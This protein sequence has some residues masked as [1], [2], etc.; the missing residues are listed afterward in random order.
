MTDATKMQPACSAKVWDGWRRTPCARAGKVE[1]DG[2]WFCR[3]HDP[4]AIAA[5]RAK[6]DAIYRARMAAADA[7]RAEAKRKDDLANACVEAIR[8]IA[9]G[10]NE[11]RALAVETLARF[12]P[13]KEASDG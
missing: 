3:Q 10:H 1:R 13:L 11:P 5:R 4:V 8:Q 7:A 9:A 6:S 12:A 2:K